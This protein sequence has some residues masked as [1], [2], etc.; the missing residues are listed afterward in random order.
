MFFG[1]D[2]ASQHEYYFIILSFYFNIH[3]KA[4]YL[5][6]RTLKL[7]VTRMAAPNGH[8]EQISAYL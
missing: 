4:T 8:L 5:L 1:T 6:G 2:L 7:E 3:F